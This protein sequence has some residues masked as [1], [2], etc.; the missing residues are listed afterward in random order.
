MINS[1]P[2]F[3]SAA[4]ARARLEILYAEQHAAARHGVPNE[5][6]WDQL[7]EEI[8]TTR[9]AYVGAAVTEIAVLRGHFRGRPQ[10]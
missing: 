6:Y 10:G 9:A 8:T 3:A 4:A 2:S 1:E 5:R 7:M